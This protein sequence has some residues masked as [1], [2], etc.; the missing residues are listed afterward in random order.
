MSTASPPA[1]PRT[2]VSDVPPLQVGG[3]LV[4]DEGRIDFG[5][6]PGPAVPRG[7]YP[8]FAALKVGL[9]GLAF[10]CAGLIA[11]DLVAFLMAQFE[12]GALLGW[13]T[14]AVIAAGVGAIIYWIGAEFRAIRRLRSVERIRS[15]LGAPSATRNDAEID[16]AIGA[17]LATARPKERKAYARHV[18][19]DAPSEAKIA[20]FEQNVVRPLDRQVDGAINNAMLVAFG[21]NFISP[22]ALV[23]T[24]AFIW[25][26]VALVRAIAEIYGLRPGAVATARLLRRIILNASAV[27]TADAVAIAAANLV[28]GAL[29]KLSAEVGTSTLAAQ[30][31]ARI[32]RLTQDACRPVPLREPPQS[33]TGPGAT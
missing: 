20:L 23:D 22:T 29:S 8:R 4:P 33:L 30:R 16:G 6:V 19:A 24:V 14:L 2:A 31:M 32:G 7:P 9:L 17:Y 27:G 28:G 3:A 25:R 1:E 15:V 11:L 12:R 13:L 18:A 10:L 21:I 5:P 26:A